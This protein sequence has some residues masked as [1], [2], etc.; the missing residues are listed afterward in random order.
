MGDTLRIPDPGDKDTG[1]TSKKCAA[2]GQSFTGA[3]HANCPA[4]GPTIHV[5]GPASSPTA[6]E[7]TTKRCPACGELYTGEK[8]AGCSSSGGGLKKSPS[9][10]SRIDD[11]PPE[12]QA[13]SQDPSRQLNQYILVKQ[14]GKGGMG[15]VWKAWDRKLTRWVAI[16]FLMATE[17][18]DILR[19]QR[20]A[21]LAARLRHPNIAP[22]Y[23]VGEAPGLHPGQTSRHY[24]AMEFIDGQSMAGT[25]LP[26]R[27]TLEIFIKVAQGVEAAH[28]GGVVH[29]DLKP[30]NVMLTSDRWPYVMDFGLAKA[31]QTESSIS[32]AGAVMGTPAFMPPEQA[33]GHLEEIDPQ[34]DV[35]SLGATLYAVLCRRPP[36]SGQ[37]PM[38]ILMKVCKEDPVPP[39]KLVPGIPA[40]VETIILKAMSKEKAERY[41]SAGDFAAD[42]RRYLSAEEIAA[43]APSTLKLAARKVRR[44]AWPAAVLLLLLAAGGA[45]A[46]LATRPGPRPA[47]GPGGEAVKPP[48]PP[49]DDGKGRREREWAQA[50]NDLRRLL[51][52]DDWQPGDPK[53]AGRANEHL[54]RLAGDAPGR[55]VDVA[56]W[57]AN[58]F[59]RADTRLQAAGG[60]VEARQAAARRIYD[61]CDA[62]AAAVRD[63]APLRKVSDQA[64]RLREA[65]RGV[66]AYRGKFTLKILVGPY[67]EVT[68]FARGGKDIPLAQRSSPGTLGTFDI[69]DYEGELSHPEAGKKPFRIAAGDL[70][71]GKTYLLSGRMQDGKF[72]LAEP[73]P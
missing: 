22:I 65:A 18:E 66:A 12:A 54:R 47:P 30:Q 43:S 45:I 64:A 11:L 56:D 70:R 7:V 24:L 37:S 69:D 50:W 49:P 14:I 39:R 29:R 41:A 21:K 28:K 9:S 3:E 38:E 16:K 53:L 42:L 71:D 52:Y 17:E 46:F 40:D 6:A 63:V 51:D 26:L 10:K 59:D 55:D 36:F 73:A 20:E 1:V 61:W 68:R 27:E 67:A 32:V 19:F 57:F 44:N 72:R 48:L 62:V 31:L 60:A 34:S 15:T 35:Y 58:Q 5:G 4:S 23:E 8:H 33:Q 13:L 2:C 25:E